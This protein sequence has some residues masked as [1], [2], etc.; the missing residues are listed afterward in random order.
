MENVNGNV[1][2][3]GRIDQNRGEGAQPQ[4]FPGRVVKNFGLKH[5]RILTE[6]AC[7]L[8][9]TC[10]LLFR[11]KRNLNERRAREIEGFFSRLAG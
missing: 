11:N 4:W 2:E 6:Q 9:M 10:C 7:T 1:N 5:S 3:Q 8:W